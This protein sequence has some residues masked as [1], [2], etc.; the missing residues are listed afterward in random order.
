MP[1]S[2]F[3]VAGATVP[4]EW[5]PESGASVSLP[6]LTV[7]MKNV[8]EGEWPVNF[9][10]LADTLAR[11]DTDQRV[12]QFDW[13]AAGLR[14]V[15]LSE[16]ECKVNLEDDYPAWVA[17]GQD[18]TLGTPFVTAQHEGPF[19]SDDGY[20]TSSAF[21]LG[22][23]GLPELDATRWLSL[24]RKPKTIKSAVLAHVRQPAD[25]VQVE[26]ALEAPQVMAHA[27]H[28]WAARAGLQVL[29]SIV[30]KTDHVP[31]TRVARLLRENP[32]LS[33]T[34]H[35]FD[36]TLSTGTLV[37]P[38][39]GVNA[40]QRN[41]II[42]E[43]LE[44]DGFTLC[45]PSFAPGNVQYRGRGRERVSVFAKNPALFSGVEAAA[46]LGEQVDLCA[47]AWGRFKTHRSA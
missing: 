28:A 39:V 41:P 35:A 5:S 30:T 19:F 42:Q 11:Y 32:L 47:N 24:G 21:F 38:A 4:F 9:R 23:A 25:A 37:T 8:A 10:D 16:V 22:F 15:P 3:T 40:F 12:A 14:P 45:E 26:V 46:W 18:V 1:Q 17:G 7:N 20:V 27:Q 6:S 34:V 2:T 31:Y 29:Q 33:A 13:A 36:V 43:T 44:A